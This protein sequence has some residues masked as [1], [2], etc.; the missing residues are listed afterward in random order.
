MRRLLLGSLAGVALVVATPTAASAHPLGNFTVNHYIGVTLTPTS[1]DARVVVDTAE[2]PTAQQRGAIDV[3]GNG[4]LSE[5]EAAAWARAS[6]A[7]AARD[8]AISLGGKP[9]AL[10]ITSGAFRFVPGAAG[11]DTGRL[12]CGLTAPVSIASSS[13]LVVQDLAARNRIGWHEITVVGK[14]VELIR[15]PV[16]ATSVSDELRRY[17]GDL[18]AS[19]LD[20]REATVHVRAGEG[21]STY[22]TFVSAPKAGPFGRALGAVDKKFTSL[23]GRRHATAGSVLLASLLALLLGAGHALLPGH[24]K[25]IMAAYLAGKRGSARDAITV[26]ATVTITHTVGVLLL[27]LALSLSSALAGDVVTR[28][29]ALVSGIIVVGVGIGLLRSALRGGAH[30]HNHGPGGHT[31]GPSEHEHEHGHDH[32]HHDHAHSDHGSELAHDGAAAPAALAV[33]SRPAPD[34]DHDHDHADAPRRTRRTGL[35]GMGIAGGLVPSPSALVVLLSAI[36][37]GRAWLGIVLVVLYGV[38]MAGTLTGIG[39]LL[40][41]AGHRVQRRFLEPSASVQRITRA[42]P[43]VAAIAVIAVGALLSL[44]TLSV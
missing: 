39:L 41:R 29:L 38:G 27:G 5:V 28:R 40:V 14:G 42:L 44:R 24:G 21:A 9:L 31:H 23:V 13:D 11:L 20:V 25:T 35:I 36:A 34:H 16:P 37:L 17:P 12:E 2:I 43:V 10:T 19:P 8:V 15:S 7:T 4:T 26:G 22:G 32:P 3:D 30:G 1:V 33:L 6:C 18:L